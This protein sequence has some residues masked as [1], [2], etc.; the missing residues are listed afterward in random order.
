MAKDRDSGDLIRQLASSFGMADTYNTRIEGSRYDP[1]TG[2]LYCDGMAVS[3]TSLESA[4]DFFA[5]QK[6]YFRAMASK[7]STSMEQFINYSVAYNAIVMMLS[8][9]DPGDK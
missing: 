1:A 8:Q 6:D 5:R 2:T 9:Q 7:D 3:K 4:L